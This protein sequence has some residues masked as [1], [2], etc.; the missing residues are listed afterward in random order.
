M[1]QLFKAAASVLWQR[2]VWVVIFGAALAVASVLTI[3]ATPATSDPSG[4]AATNLFLLAAAG[5][6]ELVALTAL[7]L[8][9][10]RK[11][12]ARPLTATDLVRT[13]ALATARIVFTALVLVA[14]AVLVGILVFF[15]A[16]IG[17]MFAAEATGWLLLGLLVVVAVLS[18]RLGLMVPVAIEEGGWPI[19]VMAGAWEIAE[20]NLPL[21]ALSLGGTAVAGEIVA[22]AG[23]TFAPAA[24]SAIDTAAAVVT[25]VVTAG[26]LAILYRRPAADARAMRP[27]IRQAAPNADDDRTV[28]G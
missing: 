26:L 28:W 1:G 7:T 25:T 14:F 8:V 11:L 2:L 22:I 18:P 27:A 6:L 10:L 17:S 13:T 12:D 24:G 15:M 4:A 19:D 3:V 16:F 20:R 21:A 23:A 5:L 9:L